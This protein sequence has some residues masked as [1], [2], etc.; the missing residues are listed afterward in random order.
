[1]SSEQ[2][3]RLSK[4]EYYMQIAEL[5]SARGTCCR[6]KVG[7]VIVKS[8][9]IVSTWYNGK[10]RWEEHCDG[11]HS[12]LVDWHCYVALHA[13]ENAIIAASRTGV[14]LEWATIYCTHRPCDQ[15]T[16]RVIN[17]GIIEVVFKNEY[18]WYGTI[19]ANDFLN[20]RKL[21]QLQ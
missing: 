8:W 11:W 13:E 10:A 14:A 7:A 20:I 1:M 12:C 15:C 5:A 16:R 17:A 9:V 6:A 18:Q 19:K 2:M 3:V 4:D 21:W